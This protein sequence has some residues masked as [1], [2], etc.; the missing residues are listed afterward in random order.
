MKF[1]RFV[2]DE[3][4]YANENEKDDVEN[5]DGRNG[6]H[7]RLLLAVP[8]TPGAEFGPYGGTQ[9]GHNERTDALPLRVLTILVR[10]PRQVVA[11]VRL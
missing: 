4:Q 6:H 3:T 11:D 10:E 9:N 2:V 5:G 1:A 8:V 7:S